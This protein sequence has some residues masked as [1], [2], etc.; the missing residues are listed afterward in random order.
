M[1]KNMSMNTN[2]E[3]MA[4]QMAQLNYTLSLIISDVAMEL[5]YGDASKAE[6]AD[7]MEARVKEARE[8]LLKGHK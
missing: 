1:H 2:L 6:T 5:R 4:A 3:K 8:L 7:K